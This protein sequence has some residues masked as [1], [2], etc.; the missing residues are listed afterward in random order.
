MRPLTCFT[1]GQERDA[2]GPAMCCV[3]GEQAGA[4]GGQSGVPKCRVLRQGSLQ[5][6]SGQGVPGL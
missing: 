6:D 5:G 3:P 2:S 4:G 1:Y